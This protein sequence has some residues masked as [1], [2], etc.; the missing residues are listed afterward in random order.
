MWN[1]SEY[2]KFA[3]ERARPFADLLSR[4]PQQGIA[5]IVDLGCGAGNL[6]RM[7]AERWPEATVLGVDNSPEMLD[8]ARPLGIAGRLEF[9][10]GDIADWAASQANGA[11]DL[12]VSN[13]ALHWVDNHSQL[14]AQLAGRLS[15]AG[16]LAVQMPNRFGNPSQTAIEET[17]ADP[18]WSAQL[19]GVGLHRH[20]VMPAAWYVERLR[21]LEFSVDA[22]ET[23][24]IHILR[25][26]NP[27]LEWLKGTALRPLLAHLDDKQRAEFLRILG[28]RFRTAYPPS[29]EVTLFPMPR[30][31]FVARR[32]EYVVELRG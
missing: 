30:L 28:D 12:I 31:F 26:E 27:V 24:Y 17:A 4:V 23:T 5:H 19:S 3:D 32:E 29:G 7:L 25:G 8:R 11:V 1:P 9:I 21:E 18:R 6:T 2:L 10:E 20:S 14:L 13:A 22:W 16:F 15:S